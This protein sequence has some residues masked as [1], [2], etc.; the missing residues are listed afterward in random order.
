METHKQFVY[1]DDVAELEEDLGLLLEGKKLE[2]NLTYRFPAFNSSWYGYDAAGIEKKWND[3]KNDL[4]EKAVC[5]MRPKPLRRTGIVHK[6]ELVT[7]ESIMSN[8]ISKYILP[9]SLFVCT[10]LQAQTLK[11]GTYDCKSLLARSARKVKTPL[12]KVT[13]APPEIGRAHV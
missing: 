8:I 2:H 7:K 5:F 9:L 3:R 6:P 4:P 12:Q 10:Q 11:I 13:T 1:P